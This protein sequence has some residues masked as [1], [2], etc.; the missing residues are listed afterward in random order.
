MYGCKIVL[1][2]F[3]I[4]SSV[5]AYDIQGIKFRWMSAYEVRLNSHYLEGDPIKEPADTFQVIAEVDYLDRNFGQHTDWLIYRVPGKKDSGQLKIL[6]KPPQKKCKDLILAQSKKTLENIFNFA[7]TK[8]KGKLNLFIDQRKIQ[9]LLMNE[10]L[11]RNYKLNSHAFSQT[12]IP[13]IAISF[14]KSKAGHYL[15]DGDICF[16][17]DDQCQTI[18]EDICHLCPTR[19]LEVVGNNCQRSYKKY[20]RNM[21]CGTKGA[22]ACIRG[23]KTTGM[24]GHYCV[25]GS[26]LGYCKKPLRVFCEDGEL[27]CR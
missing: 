7:I 15:K 26:P 8:E 18:Q 13:G 12:T 5:Y 21:V 3:V 14:F 10:V 24:Q 11:S 25:P 16:N 4:L 2:F 23:W 1:F 9:F 22:P 19:V 27:I 17:T 6:M 20:C